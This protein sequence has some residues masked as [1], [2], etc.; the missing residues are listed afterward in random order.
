MCVCASL[1]PFL[2]FDFLESIAAVFL[3]IFFYSLCDVCV[4]NIFGI[5]NE[6]LFTPKTLP[7]HSSNKIDICDALYSGIQYTQ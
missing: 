5:G 1:S 3:Y 4:D 7:L 2:L 6:I